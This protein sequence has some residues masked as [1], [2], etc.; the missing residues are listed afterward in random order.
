M[1]I[2][3]GLTCSPNTS[4]FLIVGIVTLFSLFFLSCNKEQD[5]HTTTLEGTWVEASTRYDTLQF[6]SIDALDFFELKRGFEMRDGNWLPKYGA[7]MYTYNVSTTEIRLKSLLSSNSEF[8]VYPFKLKSKTLQI[9]D[10]YN[11]SSGKML[12]FKKL[13]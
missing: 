1:K 4:T 11:A 2:D 10:F 7:G 12:T 13:N 8:L 3:V 6:Y 5:T 9:G